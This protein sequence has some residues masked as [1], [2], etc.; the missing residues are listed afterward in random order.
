M[1]TKLPKLWGKKFNSNLGN[2]IAKNEGEKKDDLGRKFMGKKI[3]GNGIAKMRGKKIVAID[4]WQ[5]CCR[6]GRGKKKW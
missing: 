3:C 6:N 1:A 5:C 2:E 4:L